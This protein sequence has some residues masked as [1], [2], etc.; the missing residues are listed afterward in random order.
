MMVLT[1]CLDEVKLPDRNGKLIAPSPR[2]GF[3]GVLA[4]ERRAAAELI[5]LLRPRLAHI[6]IPRYIRIM[7]QLPTTP[8]NNVEQFVLRRESVTGGTWDSG[9]TGIVVKRDKLE[10]RTS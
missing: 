5:A 10:A 1:P 4:R 7:N 8:T 3:A 6:V 2:P 9:A